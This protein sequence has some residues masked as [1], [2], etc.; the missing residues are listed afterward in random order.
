MEKDIWQLIKPLH[1]SQ[2]KMLNN[3]QM[4]FP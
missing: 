1:N 2:V 3:N 4:N